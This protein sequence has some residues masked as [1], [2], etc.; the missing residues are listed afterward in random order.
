MIKSPVANGS[1]VPACPTFFIFMVLRIFLTTSN[2]VQSN[3]LSIN[4]TLPSPQAPKEDEEA[5]EILSFSLV[6][7]IYYFLDF[8]T[9]TGFENL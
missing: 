3:G 1:S 5:S 6:F 7:S 8:S 9:L 2:D 4:K